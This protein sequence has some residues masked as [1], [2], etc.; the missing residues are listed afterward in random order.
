MEPL[1]KK[2]KKD[3]KPH[4]VLYTDEELQAKH[5]ASKNKNTTKSEN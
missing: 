5:D 1:Q 2:L 4:Y 3:K